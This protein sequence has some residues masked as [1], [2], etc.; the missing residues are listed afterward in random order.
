MTEQSNTILRDF[1]IRKTKAQKETFRAWLCAELE[2]AGYAPKVEA[3]RSLVKSHNVVV[4]DPERAE[5][6]FTA[7]YDTCAVLPFPNFITPRNFLFYLLYQILILAAMMVV[8]IAAVVVL[9]L[10]GGRIFDDPA[11]ASV[12]AGVVMYG[13]LLFFV[14]WMLGAGRANRHTANDNTSGVLTLLET[15]LA[16]PPEDR[17]KVCFVFFDNEEKGLFG[18][19]AFARRHRTARKE[20]LVVNF[21][22]V[23]DGDYLQ[24]Y[25]S[26]AVKRDPAA[27][28]ALERAF[29]GRG[30][31]ETEVYRGFAFYPS[32]Q[33]Q[34]KKGV[35]VC[36]LKKKPLLGYYMDRIHTGR[37]TVLEEENIALLR[38]GALRLAAGVKGEN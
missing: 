9:L 3:E 7:H 18:S 10:A 11:V 29:Q 6:L 13:L 4:G 22:C 17:D 8:I 32:D 38:D 21:D 27:M 16:L 2:K 36:A 19:S 37:D 33:A 1:Q 35:G 5:V 30:E 12:V 28:E 23:S 25:P 34:F 26:K 15:A 20:T 24:L 14:F 31:K